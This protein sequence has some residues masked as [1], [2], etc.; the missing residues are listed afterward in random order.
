MR[1]RGEFLLALLGIVAMSGCDPILSID[2]AFFPAWLMCLVVAGMLLAIIRGLVRRAGVEQFIG[3]RLVVYF[4]VYL[5]CT[6][7]LWL[8]FFRT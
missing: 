2:G 4:C 6:L 5:S 3:P 8:G 1:M 7:A